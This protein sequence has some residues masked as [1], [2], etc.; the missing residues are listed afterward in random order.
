MIFSHNSKIINNK[1]IS[2]IIKINRKENY[3]NPNFEIRFILMH[4]L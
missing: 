1:K 3:Q 4:F 2:L